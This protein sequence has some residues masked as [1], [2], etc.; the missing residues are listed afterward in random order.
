MMLLPTNVF[1]IKKDN[2]IMLGDKEKLCV[3]KAHQEQLLIAELERNDSSL[4][5]E[6]S[7]VDPAIKITRYGS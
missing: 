4:S 7:L 6:P 3:C 1:K 5:I 2:S